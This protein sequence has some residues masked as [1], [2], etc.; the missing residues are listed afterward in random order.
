[1]RRLETSIKSQSSTEFLTTYGWAIL[2]I[3]IAIGVIALSIGSGSPSHY[4]PSQCNI[5]PSFP[6]NGAII[7]G[8]SSVK[9]ITYAISFRNELGQPIQFA[10][11]GIKLTVM[12]LGTNGK[13]SYFGQCNPIKASEGATV[14]CNVKIPGTIEPNV[15]SKLE[16][17]FTLYYSTCQGST[18]SNT[19]LSSGHSLQQLSPPNN[20]FYL[21]KLKISPNDGYI[22]IQGTKYYNDTTVLL[23]AENY[24]IYASPFNGYSF[25]NWLISGSN[26]KS[27]S[28]QKSTLILTANSTLTANLVKII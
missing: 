16:T 25:I 3:G 19:Y 13:N 21:L 10:A 20:K 24:V 12:N 7:S 6:C 28:L 8:H 1:M 15:G 4:T 17:Y 14:L 27:T 2:L 11:N 23:Q 26:L 5:Q 22:Y 9:D 18:C